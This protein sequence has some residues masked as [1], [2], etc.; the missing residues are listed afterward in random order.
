MTDLKT[1][2]GSS[3]EFE[4]SFVK[5]RYYF[6]AALYV[7]AFQ[8]ICDALELKDY[9]LEPFQFLYIS[10]SDK[11]PLLFI[12]TDK[13]IKAAW[14]GFRISKYIYKGIDEILE[15]IYWCW[16]NKEYIIPKRVAEAN[17]VV[18]LKDNFIEV[19]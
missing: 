18:E 12:T 16:K 19:D 13:W 4:E 9:T 6:Q 8:E 17:G 11:T 10:R 15:E 14:K 3:T 7:K 5:W 2:K 1:G